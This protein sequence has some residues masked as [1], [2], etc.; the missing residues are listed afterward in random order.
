MKPRSLAVTAGVSY[1]IIFFSA[2]F[3]NFF[4]LESILK[5]PLYTIQQNHM[6][7][8]FGILAFVLTLLSISIFTSNIEL[9]KEK[10]I[11]ESIEVDDPLDNYW[12]NPINNIRIVEDKT[13]YDE[14]IDTKIE[15]FYVYDI[16]N[17]KETEIDIN[18]EYLKNGV[19]NWHD[20]HI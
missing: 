16:K 6:I 2:I 1:L 17:E 15:A 7:V 13:V 19:V 9:V 10:E 18:V 4:V 14:D 20:R 11:S 12:H 8:R 5:D 3:A